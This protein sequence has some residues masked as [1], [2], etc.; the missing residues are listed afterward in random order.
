MKRKIF[1]V[2]L[3]LVMVLSMTAVSFADATPSLGA[4]DKAMVYLQSGEVT[5]KAVVDKDYVVTASVTGDKLDAS[6]I[7][8]GAAMQNVESL[9]VDSLRSEEFKLQTNLTGDP[10]V[11]DWM[12][13]VLAFSGATVNA[14]VN[15]NDVVYTIAKTGEKAW[16]ATP[17][18][19]EAARAAYQN[20]AAHVETST[21]E[22]DSQILIPAGTTIQIGKEFLTFGKALTLDNLNAQG[23]DLTGKVLDAV[24]YKYDETAENAYV[25]NL[26]AGS[27]IQVSSSIAELTVDT[28]VTVECDALDP[29]AEDKVLEAVKGYANAR[30]YN[31]MMTEL[32]GVVDTLAYYLDGETVDVTIE[33]ACGEDCEICNPPADDQ[34][35]TP[36]TE[37]PSNPAGPTTPAGPG[38]P[39][40]DDTT[41]VGAMGALAL[42][43]VV[44]MAGVVLTRK[45]ATSK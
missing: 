34:P 37:N 6:Y 5:A 26:K 29:I 3:A 14:S 41:P 13:N 10:T 35:T 9:G 19:T 44:A 25:V 45:R 12:P 39:Q 4:N 11:S 42:A 32:V 28:T 8:I 33:T 20:I 1:S 24:S 40:T 17:D 7:T 18:T 30:D 16:K 21:A 23:D 31:G 2:V 38:T 15:G 43:A 22:A 36:P 27:M